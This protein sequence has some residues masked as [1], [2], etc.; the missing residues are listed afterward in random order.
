MNKK[1]Y[2]VLALG[3]L[4]GAL[5]TVGHTVFAQ[6][7]DGRGDLP[8]TELQTLSEV[9]ARIKSNYVTE[10]ADDELFIDAIRGM[11]SGLD[12]HSDYLDE[13]AFSDLKVSTRGEFGGLGIQ[14]EMYEGV[15]RVISPI[16]DTPAYRA[17]VKSGDLIIKLDDQI[18]KGMTFREAVNTMRGKP[19]TEI[20]LTILREGEQQPLKISVVRDVIVVKSIKSEMLENGIAYIRI[21]QF[22][23]HSSED[24]QNTIIDMQKRNGGHLNGVI[25]DLRNNPG[26]LLSSAVEI[27]DFFINKGR[28]VYTRGRID[29]AK[30]EFNAKDNDILKGTPMVVLINEG[31]ASA[32]EIVSGALQDH[33]RAV[34][35]GRKSYGK[36]SVQSIYEMPDGKTAVKLT[37]AHYY[38]PKGR[39]IHGKGIEPDIKL[40][41]SKEPAKEIRQDTDVKAALKYLLKK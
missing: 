12:P 1:N 2:A 11:V 5:L 21:T 14:V 8:I 3:V 26:G 10:V 24:L 16:D 28:I 15:V 23:S 9:F 30:K 13:E 40:E 38:T 34:I 6:R 36:A 19:G 4:L 32:S 7:Y 18:V 27:S 22:Q 41:A 35:M 37:I 20:T 39:M 33:K 25:L 17:G 31:S 29:E